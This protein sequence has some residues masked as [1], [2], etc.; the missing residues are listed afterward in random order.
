MDRAACGRA[1]CASPM[2]RARGTP[3][4]VMVVKVAIVFVLIVVR[5]VCMTS[6][7]SW[8][9]GL[10]TPQRLMAHRTATSWTVVRTLGS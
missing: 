10:G 1:G 9:S 2:S 6:G 8:D 7:V 4:V 5:G 3:L